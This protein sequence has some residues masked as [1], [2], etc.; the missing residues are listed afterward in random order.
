MPADV[1]IDT[2]VVVYSFDATA[3]LKQRRAK[4]ILAGSGWFVSWQ[5][6]QEFC[7]VA[8]HRFAVPLKQ[9]DLR[10]YVALR[11]WPRCRVLPSETL[12]AKAIEIQ[13]RFGFRFYDSLVISS[14]L[15]GGAGK[16]LSEDL[17]DGQTIGPLQ[18]VNPFR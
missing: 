14:A 11:L 6:V 17:Q 2:N 9:E 7:S 15:A 12:L 3:P 16:L 1:F 4:E 8:L 18:I 5:V 13:G 10:D